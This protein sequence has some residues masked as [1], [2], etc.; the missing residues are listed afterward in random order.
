MTVDLWNTYEI[1]QVTIKWETAYGKQYKIFT[2]LDNKNWTEVSYVKNGKGNEE[3]ISFKLTEARYVKF[4]GIERAMP[5]GYSMYEFEVYGSRITKENLEAVT[6]GTNIATNA[7]ANSSG[8]EG[9]GASA[10]MA[11]DGDMMEI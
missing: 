6:S 8:E 1:C 7:V 4:Q 2:S 5:Y 3:T 11:I 9:M 10:G